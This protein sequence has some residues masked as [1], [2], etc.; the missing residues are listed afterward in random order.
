MK[1]YWSYP[2]RVCISPKKLIFLG[3][4]LII[5]TRQPDNSIN[6]AKL[7]SIT[8]LNYGASLKNGILGKDKQEKVNSIV[9]LAKL[10]EYV[11]GSEAVSNDFTN[12]LD[13][14]CFRALFSVVSLNLAIETYRAILKIASVTISGSIFKS[15]DDSIDKYTPI[16]DSLIHCMDVI[17]IITQKLYL[18][19]NKIIFFSI[20]LVT[21]LINKS[22]K[23]NYNS[24]ILLAARLKHVN[25]FATVGNLIE[26]DDQPLLDAIHNLKIA[27]YN[28]NEYLN[29]T[30]FDLSIQS[31]QLMLNNLYINLETSLNEYGTP[32]TTDEFIKAGFTNNPKKFIIENFTIL[33]A[34]NLEIFLKD[35]NITFKKKFHE[36]LMMS[37]HSR[38]FPLCLFIEKV[39]DLWI[40]VFHNHES[41]PN[42]YLSIL[43][44]ELMI[45]YTMN[46]CLILWQE[47]KAQL[48]SNDVDGILHLLESYTINLEF[49][50]ANSNKSIEE[51]LDITS[52]H[53]SEDM[54]RDQVLNLKLKHQNFWTNRFIEFDHHL[55]SEVMD[56]VCEQRVI[57]LLK[58]SW[59]YT[60]N[61][62][63]YLL[64]NKD[65]K[66]NFKYYFILLSPNRKS[67]Y[68]KEFV[69]KPLI[70]PS[71]EEMETQSINLSDIHQFKSSKIGD[72]VGEED[73]K[74]NNKLITVR[75][76]ISYEKIVLVG[77]N[78][79]K[80][81]GFYTDTQVNKYVWLDGLKMLKGMIHEGQLSEDTEKQLDCL[82]D[83][84]RNTQLLSLESKSMGGEL[85]AVNLD[86][87]SEDDDEY[88]DLAEL[89]ELGTDNYHYR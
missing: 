50:L 35:P 8:A 58:G 40:K 9:V 36:E 49:D 77:E 21:D 70:N 17:D 6:K 25:F 54:R 68:F 31:H 26:T 59:V 19:D 82:I 76:T 80:L 69:E 61:H 29:D 64:K 11:I 2:P 4:S 24:I 72:H 7:D 20:K 73:K 52:S 27:Y 84:R 63:E 30:T 32:A 14:T 33:L 15:K 3:R 85:N 34:M 13:Y 53:N 57:Q 45:Y 56:F 48:D 88:Y 87:D 41:F 89:I 38:T 23:F 16:Y 22:L 79:K 65:K 66:S 51:I 47:T 81:L 83:I 39:T 71:F 46:N 12:I 75:G 1:N 18:T 5:L 60:E 44:W 62:G 43:S 42:I 37:D 10:L 74:K 67:V 86:K 28:L 55:A 78:N